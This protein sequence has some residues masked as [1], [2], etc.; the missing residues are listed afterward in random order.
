VTATALGGLGMTAQWDDD[1][2]HALH[3][4]LTGETGGYYADFG[5]AA[6][7]THA[8]SRAFLHDGRYSSFRRRRHGRRVDFRRTPPTRFLAALQTHDQVGNRAA[9]ERL[10]QL[11]GVERLAAGAAL[12]LALPYV[13]MLF[14]G[15]EWGASTP[16]LFFT[17]FPDAELGAAVTEGRRAEFA[18]HGWGDEVP[19]PQDPTTYARSV[20]DWDERARGTHAQLLSWYTALIAWRR[21][22]PASG[23]P[24]AQ[25]GPV[26]PARRGSAGGGPRWYAVSAGQ[27]SAVVNL[28]AEPLD[29]ELTGDGPAVV[30]HSWPS[31]GCTVTGSRLALGP[32]ATAVGRWL[33]PR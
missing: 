14:M 15:E 11:V 3:W 16:W 17:S 2:H 33:T 9:G 20:L 18:A 31:G 30:D 22:V 8:L 19:D 10:S 25:A 7:V 26:V 4:L 27:R 24:S 1:V 23:D 13:P 32:S 29:L 5:S 12:L 6:A 21:S 28:S